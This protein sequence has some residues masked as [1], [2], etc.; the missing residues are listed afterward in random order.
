MCEKTAN[1]TKEPTDDALK[2][3]IG[4]VKTH[5]SLMKTNEL[6]EEDPSMTRHVLGSTSSDTKAPTGD[7]VTVTNSAEE[8][9]ET[10]LFG[11]TLNKRRGPPKK[12]AYQPPAESL[13]DKDH[14]TN[15]ASVAA[16]AKETQEDLEGFLFGESPH[17]RSRPSYKKTQCSEASEP[18]INVSNEKMSPKRNEC[19][20][21]P[22]TSFATP[23][24]AFDL[25][26]CSPSR[27]RNLLLIAR[28]IAELQKN[29]AAG[30][31]PSGSVTESISFIS[32]KD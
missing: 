30:K 32:H 31:K 24:L 16:V 14:A 18:S 8:D 11:T 26:Q 17:K 3:S 5:L 28:D 25:K 29:I 19:H 7:T 2:E 27:Q 6:V 9:L 13:I 22:S 4:T 12:R 10:F 23:G 20:S 21:P 1:N 15:K